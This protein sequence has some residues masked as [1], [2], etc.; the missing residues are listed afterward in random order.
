MG[1][2]VEGFRM[3]FLDRRYWRYILIPW[4]WSVLIF[5]AVVVLGYIAVVPWLQGV[6]ERRIG[7][8]SL[9]GPLQAL[10]SLAYLAIWFFIAGFVF[11]TITSVTSSFLW[12]D[13]SQKVEEQITDRPAPKSSLSNAR[14]VSDSI[15]RGSFAILM[16]ILSLFC[17]WVLP[18]VAPVILAGW[19]GLLDYTSPAFLRYNRTI[20]QQWP[21]ATKMPSW[22]GFQIVSGF[23][24]LV[25][26]VNV[27]M[28]PALVAGGTAMAVRS[29]VFGKDS[30]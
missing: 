25:P 13:L 8:G 28:L 18:I 7:D 3:V 9:G 22:F 12:D 26:L 30:A 5:I 16:A 4:M 10:V 24:S 21:S 11:L 1:Y 6:I 15:S 2:V 20:G 14:I 17:G 19:V 23:L 27:L 29:G